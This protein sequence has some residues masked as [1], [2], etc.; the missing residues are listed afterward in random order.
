MAVQLVGYTDDDWTIKH[1]SFREWAQIS[2][3]F[4]KDPSPFLYYGLDCCPE[5][6]DHV[7]KRY[8]DKERAKFL[9]VGIGDNVYTNVDFSWESFANKD[10]H[11]LDIKTNII[12][13]FLPLQMLFKLLK[14]EKL[15]VLALDVDGY[16]YHALEDISEWKYILSC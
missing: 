16:E 9:C 15:D 2:E 12:Y 1:S 14:I 10:W 11:H 13:I 4:L 8:R 3:D 7:A 5:S 6:I